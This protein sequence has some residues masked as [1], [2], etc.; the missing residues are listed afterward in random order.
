MLDK[1]RMKYSII[2][3][4][5]GGEFGDIYLGINKNTN[6]KFAIKVGE[7]IDG[8]LINNEAKIYNV[9][10]DERGFPKMRLYGREDKYSYIVMDLL[11][12]SLSGKKEEVGIFNLREV[13]RIGIIMIRKL[14]KLHKKGYLHRDMKPENIMYGVG[15]DND[16]YLIDYGL[17]CGY[18]R[19]GIH[20]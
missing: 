5:G 3:R 12:I 14:E 2:K 17:S 11:G 1:L 9:L 8:I 20:V 6:K 13:I 4:L 7:D 16:I 18:I 10:A 15:D 19:G